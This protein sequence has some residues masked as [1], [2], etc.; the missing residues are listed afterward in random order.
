[1]LICACAFAKKDCEQ[2][3][4]KWINKTKPSKIYI[5]PSWPPIKKFLEENKK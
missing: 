2:H 5:I 4:P 1:M 3:C